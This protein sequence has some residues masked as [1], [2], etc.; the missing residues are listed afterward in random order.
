MFIDYTKVEL[1]AGGG[2]GGAV[3]FRREKY[4]PKGGPDG[5]DG[6]NG[7]SVILRAS[8]H[9]NTLINFKFHPSFNATRGSHGEGSN[10][11][12]RTGHDL[13]LEV[14]AGTVVCTRTNDELE[15]L[16]DLTTVGQEIQ[17]ARGGLGGVMHDRLNG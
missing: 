13:I 2:G 3:S 9:L 15:R 6:G 17:V 4:N 10:R 11:T 14:P 7:G 16:V 5:G 8:P 12:G 1:T